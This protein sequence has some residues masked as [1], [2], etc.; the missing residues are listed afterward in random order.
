VDRVATADHHQAGADHHDGDG[1]DSQ[2]FETKQPST[3]D[4]GGPDEACPDAGSAALQSDVPFAE[5]ES[6]VVEHIERPDRVHF[7][8]RARRCRATIELRNRY[9]GDRGGNGS[10]RGPELAPRRNRVVDPIDNGHARLGVVRPVI[11]RLQ[12]HDKNS[13]Y[14]RNN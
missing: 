10:D 12:A 7:E 8:K 13:A 9:R 4:V 3:G 2:N 1:H 14:A 5:Y 6:G 11:R